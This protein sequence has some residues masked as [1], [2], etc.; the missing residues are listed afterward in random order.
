MCYQNRRILMAVHLIDESPVPLLGRVKS[1]E[2][3]TDGLYK[4]ELE[5]IPVP[6]RTEITGWIAN[7]RP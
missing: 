2:Y 1:C 7:R 3:D 4:V 6:E 5:L